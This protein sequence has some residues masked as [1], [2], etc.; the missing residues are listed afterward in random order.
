ME[1]AGYTDGHGSG[2]TAGV[3]KIKA[4]KISSCPVAMFRYYELCFVVHRGNKQKR[5]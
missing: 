2:G 1:T 5:N 3:V 4:E